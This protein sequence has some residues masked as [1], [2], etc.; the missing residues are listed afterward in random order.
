MNNSCTA[1]YYDGKSSLP[2]QVS[3]IF[4]DATACFTFESMDQNLN[5]WFF[6]DISFE[7]IGADLHVQHI[8]QD[9]FVYVKITD[10]Q[11]IEKVL[12]FRKSNG[13]VGWYESLIAKSVKTHLFLAAAILGIIAL[14]YVYLIPWIGEKSVLL[15][16]ESYDN[17]LGNTFLIENTLLINSN[18]TKSK[19]LALFASELQLNNSK[20]LQFKVVDEDVVNAF[21]LPDGTVVVYTGILKKMKT[22][23]ELVALLGHEAAHINQRHSMKML[24]RNLSGYIFVSAIL[25]DANGVM[26]VLGDN[27]NTLQSLSFSRKFEKEA[28]T[29]GFKMMVKNRINPTGMT[30]LFGRLQ[31]EGDSVMPE[32]LSS[33]PVTKERIRMTKDMVEKEK[34][35]IK[36]NFKLKTLFE[37]LKK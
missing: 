1:T 22:Y 29:D 8:V 10:Q 17:K 19:Q 6:K 36:E 21:A 12:S 34:Y 25:G 32:F 27:V 28:D 26:T 3:L 24:C 31:D 14:S 7:T 13:F 33:H 15:I 16:P 18:D 37:D 23:E 20:K 4:E 5:K 35:E 9:T 11:F 2:Q 30:R